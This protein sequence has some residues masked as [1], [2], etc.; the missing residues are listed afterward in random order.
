MVIHVIIEK[1]FDFYNLLMT[2]YVYN[3]LTTSTRFN[4]K[5]NT[6]PISN[7]TLGT[8]RCHLGFISLSYQLK[9]LHKTHQ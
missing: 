7:I 4:I 1:Y 5:I 6:Q 3:V 8:H 2:G 9:V